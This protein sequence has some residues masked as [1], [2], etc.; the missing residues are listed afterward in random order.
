MEIHDIE[1]IHQNMQQI[2]YLNF[3]LTTDRIW[4]EHHN[5]ISLTHLCDTTLFGWQMDAVSIERVSLRRSGLG[6]IVGGCDSIQ[7]VH[8][9][10]VSVAPYPPPKNHGFP[11]FLFENCLNI[12]IINHSETINA[13]RWVSW[14]F[15][16]H[17]FLSNKL[18]EVGIAGEAFPASLAP[19]CE[20]REG[21]RTKMY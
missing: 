1:E 2:P 13:I 9:T 5:R 17:F 19:P 18:R 11:R 14:H 12:W 15:A 21:A 20:H 16:C 6:S 10:V 3:G 8:T 7:A 4:K